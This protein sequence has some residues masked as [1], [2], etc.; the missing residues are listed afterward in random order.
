MNPFEEIASLAELY[1]NFDW[2]LMY[3]PLIFMLKLLRL[4]FSVLW[5]KNLMLRLWQ[6]LT[7]FDV[8]ANNLLNMPSIQYLSHCSIVAKV[9]FR[10]SN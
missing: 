7:I 3:I 1:L 6:I 9:C 10:Q 2:I 4:I 5:N 8:K